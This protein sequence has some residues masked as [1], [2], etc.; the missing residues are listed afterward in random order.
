MQRTQVILTCDMPHSKETEAGATVPFSLDGTSYELDLCESDATKVRKVFERYTQHA[1]LA[2]SPSPRSFGRKSPQP[3][4]KITPV[5][6]NGHAFT[7][8]Q[9]RDWAKEQGIKVSGRG[10]IPADVNNKYAAAH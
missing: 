10:R 3:K 5:P 6:S 4:V 9:V 7:P 2:T 1:R 8:Q